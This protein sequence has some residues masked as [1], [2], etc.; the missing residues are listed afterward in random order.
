VQNPENEARGNSLRRKNA[1]DRRRYRIPKWRATDFARFRR[2]DTAAAFRRSWHHQS[3]RLAMPSKS[4]ATRRA[5]SQ[6][7]A[8]SPIGA[9]AGCGIMGALFIRCSPM[10][11]QYVPIRKFARAYDFSL[12]VLA[13]WCELRE[14]AFAYSDSIGSHRSRR[15]KNSSLIRK[16]AANDSLRKEIE[17]NRHAKRRRNCRNQRK[18]R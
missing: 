17:Q 7:V 2:P 13:G 5:K 3:Q 1:G 16:K 11:R 18:H 12:L 14:R 8:D 10:M 15:A 6:A 9:R 4:D